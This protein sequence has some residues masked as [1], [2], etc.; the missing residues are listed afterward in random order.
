[1]SELPYIEPAPER[2]WVLALSG[3]GYRGLFTAQVLA[4][5]EAEVGPLHRIFDLMAGT[6]IGSILALGLASNVSAA[7]LVA[8]FEREGEA[9]FPRLSLIQRVR[10]LVR[11]KYPSDALQ[12]CLAGVFEGG[13]FETLKTR[14]IV[15]AV[16]L[17]DSGPA[18]FRTQNGA[19]ARS[20]AS[21]KDAALASAAAPTYF[22]PHTIG[23]QQY[24]DGGLIANSPDAVALV[25]A[26][27]VLG[28]PMGTVNMLS[29]GTTETPTGKAYQLKPRR[30]GILRWAWK[31]TLLEQMMAAQAKLARSSARLMLG[32]R[33]VAIDSI[34]GPDQSRVVGLD[35]ASPQATQT[36][37]AMADVAWDDIRANNPGLIEALKRRRAG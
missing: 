4:R 17:T 6:S 28:W 22:P 19:Q 23:A 24:V 21:L 36:L 30:W 34:R 10:T 29:I 18:L 27:A 32:S 5:L 20:S 14:V 1:M 13:G 33:F 35:R 2:R 16:A 11:S 7:E 26:T 3:G 12:T 8:F 9:I 15:P 31:L 25:E 37:K